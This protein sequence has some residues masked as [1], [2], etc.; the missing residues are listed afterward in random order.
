MK[1]L[2]EAWGFGGSGG[3][4]EDAGADAFKKVFDKTRTLDKAGPFEPGLY[5]LVVNTAIDHNRLA[6]RETTFADVIEEAGT[7]DFLRRVGV[8]AGVQALPPQQPDDGVVRHHLH[9]DQKTVLESYP[10][11]IRAIKNRVPA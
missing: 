9:F 4:A 7:G 6:R 2:G 5:R 11:P 3:A 1:A 8:G 10:D